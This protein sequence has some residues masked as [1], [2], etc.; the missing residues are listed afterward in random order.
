MFGHEGIMDISSL[1]KFM[2]LDNEHCKSLI[3]YFA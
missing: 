3:A 2:D 1:T